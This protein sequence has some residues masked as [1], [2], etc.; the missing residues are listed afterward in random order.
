MMA[1]VDSC[2]SEIGVICGEKLISS[3]ETRIAVWVGERERGRE[4]IKK[5]GSGEELETV[6]GSGRRESSG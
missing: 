6:K 2:G 5:K 1:R 3:V 4:K